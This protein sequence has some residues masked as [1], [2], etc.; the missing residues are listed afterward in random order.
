[1][2]KQVNF[3]R[4]NSQRRN[5]WLLVVIVV[6]AVILHAAFFLSIHDMPLALFGGQNLVLNGSV[7][8]RDEQD[9]KQAHKQ[10]ILTHV[11]KQIVSE[12]SAGVAAPLNQVGDYAPPDLQ[13]H[14][15][16]WLNDHHLELDL[17][18]DLGQLDVT[19]PD[20]PS[21][22]VEPVKAA[23]A[24]LGQLEILVAQ[25]Y[26]IA[27][28]KEGLTQQA[29]EQGNALQNRSGMRD[30]GL[31]GGDLQGLQG[32]QTRNS[33]DAGR[34]SEQMRTLAGVE[35]SN[36]VASSHDFS[37]VVDYA[38]RADGQGYLFRL[39]LSP[40]PEVQFKTIAHNVFF[41]LDRSHSISKERYAASKLAVMDAL[42]LLR[43][44]DTFNIL[45]FDKT[46]AAFA[47]DN[48][49]ATP[50]VV[51]AAR[52]FLAR[53]PHGGL[54][55]STDLYTS[56]GNI[57]PH[58]VGRKELNTAILLSDGQTNLSRDR[59]CRS[60][61][62]WSHHNQGK[63]ALYA[64]AAGK[65]NNLPLLDV[66][67]RFNKGS[68]YH[69]TSNDQIKQTLTDLLRSLQSPI[70]KD[71]TGSVVSVHEEAVVVL[72][73][74]HGVM[75]NL[76]RDRPYVL[77][78]S[79]SRLEDFFLFL[80]GTYYDRFLDIKQRI[81]F[82]DARQVPTQELECQWAVLQAHDLYHQFLKDG[83]TVTLGEARRILSPYGIPVAFQ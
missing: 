67:S 82:A 37:V 53:E 75:S 43:P 42:E 39:T 46:V 35:A 79:A 61:A 78:G 34:D 19:F 1:M 8:S 16:S 63:V 38:P 5:Q 76:F 18:V 60:I 74:R 2:A 71:L 70:G 31:E 25:E 4:H 36:R 62:A 72:A 77:Y 10:E 83:N 57:V 13:P 41:L 20:S 40:K 64:L 12:A 27:A 3:R 52:E 26:D 9:Q 68:A 44:G 22:S 80:Q 28:A 59:Q 24:L 21:L 15:A 65:G 7:S 30:Y 49:P 50:Q 32:H 48:V 73:P 69:C 45:V 17:A 23:E 54:F 6:M 33:G 56:L 47:P 51:A 66:L 29:F 55:A 58:E 11:F 14:D 81:S